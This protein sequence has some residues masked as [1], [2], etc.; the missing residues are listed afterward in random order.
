MRP[1]TSTPVYVTPLCVIVATL[2]PETEPPRRRR[3]PSLTSNPEADPLGVN[4]PPTPTNTL[5]LPRLNAHTS[6][7]L[8]VTGLLD[9]LSDPLAVV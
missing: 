6:A 9:A 7:P 8:N 3:E 4:P 1:S 5:E 2:A